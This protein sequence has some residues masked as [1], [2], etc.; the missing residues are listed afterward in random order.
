MSL[1]EV[2][3]LNQE[4]Q[5]H[6]AQLGAALAATGTSLVLQLLTKTETSEI[7][8]KDVQQQ[9]ESSARIKLNEENRKLLSLVST[10]KPLRHQQTNTSLRHPGTGI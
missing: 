3:E 7:I 8:L 5:S 4:I 9:L 10:S 1:S 6:N 2:R